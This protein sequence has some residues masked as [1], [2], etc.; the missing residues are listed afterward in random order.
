M[1]VLALG[2]LMQRQRHRSAAARAAARAAAAAATACLVAQ[3]H[4][5]GLPS[6]DWQWRWGTVR[7]RYRLLYG[8]GL[9][10]VEQMGH[11]VGSGLGRREQG[12]LLPL[13][14]RPRRD[15]EGLM[16]EGDRMRSGRAGGVPLNC[17]VRCSVQRAAQRASR[18][19][20]LAG[21]VMG[22]LCGRLAARGAV[23]V[24]AAAARRAVLVVRA[25][26][27]ELRRRVTGRVRRVGS[28][29]L[30]GMSQQQRALLRVK[31]RCELRGLSRRCRLAAPWRS[32]GLAR[33]VGGRVPYRWAAPR[34]KQASSTVENMTKREKAA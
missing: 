19:A 23:L 11:R 27:G 14:P 33:C 30:C 10:I 20:T 1:A 7:A 9:H 26:Q 21:E 34:P 3:E 17:F 24:S 4:M 12:R 8:R 2:L 5:A 25:M 22:A 16:A 31:R 28:A 13:V 6:W 18:A 15:R 32:H 29:P